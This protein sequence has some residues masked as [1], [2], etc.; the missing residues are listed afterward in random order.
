M[1]SLSI[2]TIAT[3]LLNSQSGASHPTLMD[4]L[5]GAGLQTLTGVS[6]S[7]GK[8]PKSRSKWEL[9][10]EGAGCTGK[11]EIELNKMIESGAPPSD[12]K[13][14]LRSFC[15]SQ[16][17]AK[18]QQLG[19][20]DKVI[21]ST[22]SEAV[23]VLDSIPEESRL[24]AKHLSTISSGFCAATRK[25]FI[26]EV[27]SQDPEGIGPSLGVAHSFSD[28]MAL[29]GNKEAKAHTGCC[30]THNG[31]GC[32]DKAIEIC[33]CQGILGNGKPSKFGKID[34]HCCTDEWDLTCTE[35]VEWFHC[36]ACPASDGQPSTVVAGYNDASV[37]QVPPNPKEEI[38]ARSSTGGATG[39]DST[40]STGDSEDA[41]A[42]GAQ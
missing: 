15:I 28:I 37:P 19:V 12:V 3:N 27:K 26:Q 30:V 24:D 13:V 32:F 6:F 41:A 21:T 18:V 2:S 23:E 29:T 17:E 25:F 35:N 20:T 14:L 31:P 7:E 10:P 4:A 33:V 39:S 16:F 5:Q 9:G 40:G 34:S 38:E 22:C 36:A 42:T 8:S 1:S 11:I